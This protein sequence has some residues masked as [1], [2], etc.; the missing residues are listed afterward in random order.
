MKTK[1][2]FEA[3]PAKRPEE[4]LGLATSGQ[5]TSYWLESTQPLTSPKH[6][7]PA[8][9]DVVIIGGGIAGLSVAYNL[10]QAGKK[11][12][13]VEDGNIGSGETG[14]TTAHLVTALDDRYYELQR[15]FGKKEAKLIASSH[16]DAI[17]FIDSTV[18][19][20]NIHCDFKRVDGYLF[21]H[22][23]DKAESIDKELQACLDAGLPC[24]KVDQVPGM[25]NHT[26]PAIKFPDQAKFHPLKYLAGLYK[27]IT[28]KGG[29]ILTNTHADKI[30]A[31]GIVTSKGKEIKAAHIVVATNAPVNVKYSLPLK[32]YAFRTYVITAKIKKDS[33]PDALWWDTGDFEADAEIPPYHYVRLQPYDHTHDLLI[34]GGEDHA[35]GMADVTGIS[36]A[37]RYEILERWARERYPVEEIVHRWSG[38]VME[39]MDSLAYIGRSPGDKNIY[40]VTGDSG[41]GLTHAT[42][43]GK[44]I[45]DLILCKENPLEEIY[46]PTRSKILKTGKTFLKE[47]GIGLWEYLKHKSDANISELSTL[48]NNIGKIIKLDGKPYGV[49]KDD[50]NSLHFVEAECTHMQCIIKWNSDEK[51]W[52]CPCH[53]SRFSLEGKVLNGPAN[54]DLL[55]WLEKE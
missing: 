38:Q 12:V 19:R 15:I 53:G 1:T 29:I 23:S 49:F 4:H 42:I 22:P 33:L 31:T 34:C 8:K 51:T 5:H 43:A 9:T 32:Q 41:N 14:R 10:I 55:Y 37:E 54:T 18:S 3:T 7:I 48:E 50:E 17:D 40:V 2:V 6:S 39:P 44:L 35:T 26:G 11:I 36:E 21:L 24:S 47:Y 13:L 27:A 16:A 20:E 30:D 45:T 46:S 52:D 25:R 28:E